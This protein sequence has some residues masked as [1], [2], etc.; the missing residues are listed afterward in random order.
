MAYSHILVGASATPVRPVIHH[1]T[2][3]DLFQSL[4]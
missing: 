1:F 2:T 4:A 3:S